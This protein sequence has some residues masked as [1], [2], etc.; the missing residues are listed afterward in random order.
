MAE[1][2]NED[3]DKQKPWKE[4]AIE[5]QQLF[6]EAFGDRDWDHYESEMEYL[7]R[8]VGHAMF[9]PPKE[10]P[11]EENGR[12]GTELLIDFFY[13]DTSHCV[14]LYHKQTMY[15]VEHDT[16]VSHNILLHVS[17]HMNPNQA[18]LITTI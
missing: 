17:V 13:S 6:Y 1:G 18:L 11:N 8:N 10:L 2:P 4:A 16:I 15:T 3:P 5:L 9:G 12:T 7:E 14:F